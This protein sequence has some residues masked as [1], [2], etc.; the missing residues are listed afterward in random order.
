MRIR[1]AGSMP[2]LKELRCY[3]IESS[4][5]VF[6]EL[7]ARVDD[8][9]RLVWRPGFKIVFQRIVCKVVEDLQR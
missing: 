2:S 3:G 7:A 9:M 4:G 8:D 6:K 1:L 5:V